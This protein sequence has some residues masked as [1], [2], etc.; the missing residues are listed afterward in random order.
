[1][2]NTR[3]TTKKDAA[4]IP[5]SSDV[6]AETTAAITP[7]PES[8]VAKA[9]AKKPMRRKAASAKP[10][11][12]PSRPEAAPAVEA[13]AGFVI[14]AEELAI[15]AKPAKEHKAKKPKLVRDSFTFPESDYALIAALKQRA[16]NA[17][18]EI[19]KSEVLRAGLAALTAMAGP[20]LLKALAEVE[21]IKIGRPKK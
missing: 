18:H 8:H 11:E 4:P 1:M 16:L 15:P 9:P 10:A 20:E 13:Q 6:A 12:K 3:S 7:P 17:G 14:A 2:K 5:V 21:R 19:K